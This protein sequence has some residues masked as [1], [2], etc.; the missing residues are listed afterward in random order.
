MQEGA[1]TI[2]RGPGQGSEV[3]TTLNIQLIARG[4]S[5]SSA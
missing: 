1:A 3:V 5:E 2:I 4:N